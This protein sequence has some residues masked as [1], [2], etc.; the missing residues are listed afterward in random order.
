MKRVK[1][2]LKKSR[3]QKCST[4]HFTRWS[5]YLYTSLAHFFISS[6]H[7]LISS[8]LHFTRWSLLLFISLADFFISSLHSLICSSLHSLIYSSLLLTHWS[9]HLFSWLTDLFISSLHPL[10]FAS[11]CSRNELNTKLWIFTCIFDGLK[12]YA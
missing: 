11:R 10:N 2:C 6:L 7:S 8:S 9:V 3:I 4:L 12:D 1:I 5:L